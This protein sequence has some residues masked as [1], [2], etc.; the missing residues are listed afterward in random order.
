MLAIRTHYIGATDTKP[1]RIAARL[2]D[3]RRTITYPHGASCPHR[4]AA[5]ALLTAQ[6]LD[7]LTILGSGE[8]PDGSYA[9]LLT[10]RQEG[11]DNA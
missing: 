10:A 2:G 4:Y 3:W 5:E 11:K 6:G 7:N 1:S 8:L 9:H